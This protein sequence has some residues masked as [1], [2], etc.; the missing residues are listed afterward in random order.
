MHYVRSESWTVVAETD[1]NITCQHCHAKIPPAKQY[2]L[3]A[4]G[5]MLCPE[6]GK[7]WQQD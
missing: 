6:C 5:T 4:S 2:R 7:T 1:L 3:D